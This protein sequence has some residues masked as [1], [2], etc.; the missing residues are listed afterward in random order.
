MLFGLYVLGGLSALVAVAVFKATAL[1]D[2]SLPFYMEMPPYRFPSIRNVV[3][4]M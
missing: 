2:A 1:R 3:T 4:T